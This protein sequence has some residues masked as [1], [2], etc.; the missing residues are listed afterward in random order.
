MNCDAVVDA[1]FG[2]GLTREVGGKYAEVIQLI[3][4]AGCPVISVDIPS[5]VDGDTGQVM[6]AAVKADATVTFGLPKY[7]N[8]LYPGFEL[9]GRLFVTHISFPPEMYATDDMKVAINDAIPLPPGDVCN[10]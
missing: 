4:N 2:T 5:G 1:I 6:G 9:G 8:L 10:R 7:G 3:N